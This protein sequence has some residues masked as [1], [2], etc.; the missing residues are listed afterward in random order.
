MK[1]RE[2][3]VMLLTFLMISAGAYADEAARVGIMRLGVKA[4]G[5][6]QRDAEAITD[7]LTRMLASSEYIAVID[8]SNLEAIAREHRLSLSGLVDSRT[9]TEL[10][11][12][13]GVQYIITG[14][15]THF[16]VDEETKKSD[17][18]AM[19]NDIAKKN[20]RWGDF[21]RSL[22]TETETTTI[23]AEVALEVRI[24]DIST[25]E[26]ALA[27]SET[28]RAENTFSESKSGGGGN[29]SKQKTA[30]QSE[31]ISD[32]VSRIGFRIREA[33]AEEYPQ[34]LSAKDGDIIISIGATSGVKAGS[35]YKISAEGEEILDMRGRVIGRR[36]SIVAVVSVSDVQNDFCVAHA[37]KK[38][39]NP[40]LIQRGDRAEPV[41]S[42]EAGDIIRKK[43][44]LAS[45]PRKT[46]GESALS[47][48]ELDNRLNNIA[49]ESGRKTV[50]SVHETPVRE[51]TKTAV[52]VGA[53]F[54]DDSMTLRRSGNPSK[55][56]NIST[57]AAKVISSYGLSD[58]E[59]HSLKEHHRNAE[60]MLSRDEKFDR[61]TEL[62]RHFPYDYFSAYQAA[63]IAFDIGHYRE[64]KEWSEKALSVNPRYTPAKRLLKAATANI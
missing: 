18:R 41:S 31:A 44:F 34:V 7:E 28:G 32:A 21:L 13:A 16:S 29:A 57:N 62:F 46:L 14:A 11:R 45:R 1:L 15:V 4:D 63:K 49:E 64:A 30:I 55:L 22:G 23:K 50:S 10:G 33:I 36:P 58:S 27:M 54:A 2:V 3:F 35:L 26:V 48:A 6:S 47:G 40:S 5:V 53:S 39:G 8:R 37:V 25:T 43:A 61:Y 17:S 59:T 52:N 24:I 9:A 42:Q 51:E 12:M 60:R 38:G 19:W 20:G 56:E